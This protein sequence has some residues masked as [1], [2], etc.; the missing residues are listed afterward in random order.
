MTSRLTAMS[1]ATE[2]TTFALSVLV[3]VHDLGLQLYMGGE[4]GADPAEQYS[5]AVEGVTDIAIGLPGYT[6]SN[7]PKTLLTELPSVIDPETGTAAIIE[8]IDMLPDEYRPVQL[9]SL[10]ANEP[11]YLLTATRRSARSRT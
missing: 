11:G 7:F 3:G 10:L 1:R 5:R 6:A 9:V 8:I 2:R 4:P